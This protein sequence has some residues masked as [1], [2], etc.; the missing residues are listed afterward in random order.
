[1]KKALGG[2][3]TGGLVGS[4]GGAHALGGMKANIYNQASHTQVESRPS[5]DGQGL[6]IT[7]LDVVKGGIMAGQL[8]RS[9]RQHFGASPKPQGG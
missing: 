5:A 3:A 9:M 7:I 8:D 1:M 6:E 4:S 2:L